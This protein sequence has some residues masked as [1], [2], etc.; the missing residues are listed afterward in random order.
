MLSVTQPAAQPPT[1][2]TRNSNRSRSWPIIS[3]APKA[4]KARSI[5]TLAAFKVNFPHE[6]LESSNAI[7]VYFNP[8][9][10]ME[11]VPNFDDIVSGL[12]KNGI[13]LTAS[14]ENGISGWMRSHTL[15]PG[16]GHRL[17][18]EFSIRSIAAAFLLENQTEDYVLEY[19]LRRHS[20]NY[21]RPRYPTSMVD[22]H[23]SHSVRCQRH[24]FPARWPDV[25]NLFVGR[26][27]ARIR[28]DRLGTHLG[29][30]LVLLG[31][32]SSDMGRQEDCSHR[33]G[34][35]RRSG[36][37]SLAGITRASMSSD[38]SAVI[39]GAGVPAVVGHRPFPPMPELPEPSEPC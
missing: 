15:S 11:I 12:K 33:R 29:L 35:G 39:R 3:F 10:G 16:F 9:E 1:C 28:R 31:G 25:K 23:C 21:Y 2:V 38:S 37:R 30:V 14:E 17:V 32:G 26:R 6:L 13:G 8:N 7:G 5:D 20:G 19:L 27:Q 34:G 22:A 24:D 18:E 36:R 4:T